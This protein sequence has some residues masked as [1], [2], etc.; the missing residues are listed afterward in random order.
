MPA[1]LICLL[2]TGLSIILQS[3]LNLNVD[4]GAAIDIARRIADGQH[5]YR[6]LYEVNPP[7]IF[8]L[9]LPAVFLA[10][11][12]H[13]SDTYAA[14]IYHTSLALI[15]LA[16]CFQ[17]LHVTSAQRSPLWDHTMMIFLCFSLLLLPIFMLVDHFG[18]REHFFMMFTLPY[19]I[20]I[21]C[22]PE[23]RPTYPLALKICVGLLA[24]IGFSIKPFFLLAFATSELI[25]LIYSRRIATIF[26][27]ETIVCA[28]TLASYPIL[29]F[30]A[31]PEYLYTI[32][33]LVSRT[34]LFYSQAHY[35]ALRWT[36]FTFLFLTGGGILFLPFVGFFDK[37]PQQRSLLVI[38]LSMIII[39][40]M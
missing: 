26:T 29:I 22:W 15:S 7:C 35:G 18:Q 32:L 27:V 21:F 20:S 34:Y 19:F 5:L 4:V 30:Y 13:W 37:S 28:I 39:G 38:M 17:V 40:I 14:A 23:S 33:P 2:I 12:F 24:G 8:Y 1:L 16:S 9:E 36:I 31:F 6:D 11:H 25:R 3:V 10:D